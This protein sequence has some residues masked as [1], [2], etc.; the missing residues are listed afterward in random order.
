MA[1]LVVRHQVEDFGKWKGV[2]DSVLDLRRS[3]GEISALVLQAD[4]DSNSILAVFEW[5]SLEKA[6][7]YAASPEL[8]EAMARAGVVGPPE[9]TFMNEAAGA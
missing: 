8:K 2:F 9:I 5:E 3:N 4:G 1:Y 7:A 6:R